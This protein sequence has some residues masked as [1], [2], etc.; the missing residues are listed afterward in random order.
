MWALGD[1]PEEIE[2]D[3][4]YTFL[5][6]EES[7]MMT[8]DRWRVA[9]T[10]RLPVSFGENVR[11]NVYYNSQTK[12]PAPAVIWLHPY[13]YSSGYNEGYGVQGT[14]VYHRLAK[15]GFVVLCYDQC[16][17][18][19]RLLEGRD[20]YGKYPAWSKLGRMVHDVQAAVDFLAIGRGAVQG[21]MPPVD[22][23]RIYVLGYSLG[24]MVGLYATALDD[25]I[26]GV[27]SFCG[28]TPLRTDTDQKHT[29]GI[30]RLSQWH[31]LQPRLGLFDGR[32]K[33]IPYDFDDVLA[34]IAPRPCLVYSPRRDRE[35]DFDDVVECVGRARPVWEAHGEG[36]KLNHQAPDDVNRFQ[37]EQQDQFLEWIGGL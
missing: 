29:G 17:F 14:T 16:G 26:A 15:E 22:N 8:H 25:R 33:Q 10:A 32:E 20:F 5:T 4:Q 34:L 21:E 2:W 6:P 1:K 27:A 9:G 36:S 3:G 13:S 30:R 18:G 35:S 7:A 28:F 23:R 37:A 12:G 19:L 24:G 11:G 31:S